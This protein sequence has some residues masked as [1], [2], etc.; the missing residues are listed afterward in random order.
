M[1]GLA[2]SE[3]RIGDRYRIGAALLEVTQP[4]VTCYRVG[5]RMDEPRMASRLVA[6]YAPGS[7]SVCSKRASWA[8][9]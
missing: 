2:D 7:I 4:R 5:I 9:R 6:H 8:G 3:V 1:E